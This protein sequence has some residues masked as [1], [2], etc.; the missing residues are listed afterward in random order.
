MSPVHKLTAMG[1]VT[2][3]KIDYPS[4]LAGY[5]D[6][7]AMVRL[8]YAVNTGN[9]QILIGNIP[10]NFQDLIVVGSVR[11]SLAATTDNFG[12]EWGF[13]AQYSYT[14]LIGN[15]S[16]ATSSRT[17]GASGIYADNMPAANATSGLFASFVAHIPNYANTTTNKTAIMRW[18]ADRNG[19]GQT[20]LTVGMRSNTA[21]VTFIECFGS[22]AVLA[23]GSTVAVYGVKASAA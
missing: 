19:A 20:E 15:G 9:A 11:G 17:T 1:S 14:R 5:G 21:A 23:T 8:G 18:A 13:V 4:M 16:T 7:G 3:N 2:T 10:Q 12:F 22:S 6:F